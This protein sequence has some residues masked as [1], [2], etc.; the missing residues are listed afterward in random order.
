MQC[1]AIDHRIHELLDAGRGPADDEEIAAHLVAC[2]RCQELVAAY[3]VMLDGVDALPAPQPSPGY[4]EGI[5]WPP[6]A[7][8]PPRRFSPCQRQP[9]PPEPG[10]PASRLPA[11]NWW[12]A[13]SALAVAASL[14]LFASRH[15]P[16]EVPRGP[17]PI[18]GATPHRLA[19]SSM[20]H[21]PPE[22]VHAVCLT[23]GRQLVTLPA[24]VRR[25][26]SEVE[27]TRFTTH[28]RPVV[29]PMGAVWEAVKRT[30][31]TGGITHPK[32]A[33]DTGWISGQ[34]SLL[35]G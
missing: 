28:I 13:V 18:L 25:V 34:A 21:V 15:P 16:G 27:A 3:Q 1:E 19:D 24:T 22:Q 30:F 8:P 20:L 31:P 26:T 14:L 10:P 33:G 9:T 35:T 2:A 11:A 23:T 12:A 5:A 6:A 29:E 17:S 7:V 32:P 4:L